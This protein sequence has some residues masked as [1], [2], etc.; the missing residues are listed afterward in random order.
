MYVDPELKTLI[1]FSNVDA[2][3]LQLINTSDL[4]HIFPADLENEKA[5][6]LELRYLKEKMNKVAEEN[7]KL[8]SNIV[9]LRE[10]NE[11]LNDQ[12]LKLKQLQPDNE[13]KIGSDINLHSKY[14]FNSA[15]INDEKTDTPDFNDYRATDIKHS[16]ITDVVDTVVSL[17]RYK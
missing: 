16:S 14:E 7:K 4:K 1:P 9:K 3:T 10:E 15:S 2:K 11:K 13:R 17:Q 6:T 5:E 12:L 8:D